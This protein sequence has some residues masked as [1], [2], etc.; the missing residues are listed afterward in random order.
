MAADVM[1]GNDQDCAAWIAKHREQPAGGSGRRG[2]RAAR[3]GT[4]ADGSILSI[5]PDPEATPEP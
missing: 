5:V 1:M 2:G 4:G 3:R